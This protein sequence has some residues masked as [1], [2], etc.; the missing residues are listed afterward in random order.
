MSDVWAKPLEEGEPAREG[1]MASLETP[2]IYATGNFAT[3]REDALVELVKRLV[4]LSRIA[5]QWRL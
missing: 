3:S 2:S 1:F 5:R 4:W